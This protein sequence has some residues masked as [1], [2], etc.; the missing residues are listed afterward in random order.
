MEEEPATVG[1]LLWGDQDDDNEESSTEDGDYDSDTPRL[2]DGEYHSL[3]LDGYGDIDDDPS[4][5]D[6]EHGNDNSNLACGKRE[7]MCQACSVRRSVRTCE[8]CG[9]LTCAPCGLDGWT[10]LACDWW[11]AD[12]ETDREKPVLGPRTRPAT[13]PRPR[14]TRRERTP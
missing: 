8:A 2:A 9:C 13:R 7:A 1:S 5:A 10:C 14:S 3:A 12:A 4:P 11:F 6:C